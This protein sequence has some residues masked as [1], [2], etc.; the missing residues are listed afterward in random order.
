MVNIT[1]WKKSVLKQS[2]TLIQTIQN[3][4]LDR[5]MECIVA[6]DQNN[7]NQYQIVIAITPTKD[8]VAIDDIVFSGGCRED[9]SVTTIT[10]PHPTTMTSTNSGPSTM[11][12]GSTQSPMQTHSHRFA[13]TFGYVMLA[14]CT[15]FVIMISAFRGYKKLFGRSS[16][17][18]QSIMNVTPFETTPHEELDYQNIELN[19]IQHQK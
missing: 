14:I 8:A 4:S 18:R 3:R 13:S 16:G 10:T 2:L 15:S 11:T 1:V 17:D 9:N 12:D 5:W 7:E 6:I 19:T